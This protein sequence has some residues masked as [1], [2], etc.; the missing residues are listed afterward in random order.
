MKSL[1]E[2]FSGACFAHPNDGAE[3]LSGDFG[4][5]DIFWPVD[6]KTV[7]LYQLPAGFRL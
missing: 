2:D 3:R 4:Q 6:A 1:P 5:V 7:V